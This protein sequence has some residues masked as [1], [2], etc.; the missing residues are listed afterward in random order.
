MIQPS[1]Q[2][3]F[4]SQDLEKYESGLGY[5]QMERTWCKMTKYTVQA[6]QQLCKGI[7]QRSNEK[8]KCNA[9]RGTTTTVLHRGNSA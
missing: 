2:I 1:K 6:N 5:K 8:A 4:A 7:S 9:Q 3:W